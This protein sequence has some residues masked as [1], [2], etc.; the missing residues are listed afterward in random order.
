M[1]YLDCHLL[2]S[3]GLQQMIGDA[4]RHSRERADEL[5]RGL[6]PCVLIAVVV[7]LVIPMMPPS[8]SI[9]Y[10]WHEGA[11]VDIFC[12][13]RWV[14]VILIVFAFS[15]CGSLK[16]PF[17]IATAVLCGA[18]L[19]STYVN[20]GSYRDWAYDWFAY[21][22]V[23]LLV[24]ALCKTRPKEL[25]WGILVATASMAL[26]NVASI[27]ICPLGVYDPLVY[28]YGNRN[29]AYQLSF[30]MMTCTLLLDG[31][32]GASFSAR[33]FVVILL[34]VMQVA[35]AHSVTSCIA[36]AFAVIGLI[37]I[38]WSAPRKVLNGLTMVAAS[39]L[40]FVLVV[41]CRIQD[42]LAPL[43]SAL[44]KNV[45][46]SG[47]TPIWDL[48]LGLFNGEG[49]VFGY[50]VSGNALIQVNGVHYAH[51]HNIYLDAWF[52]GGLVALLAMGALVLM[53]AFRLYRL[54]NARCFAMLAIMLGAY[55]IV[56][57]TEPMTRVSFFIFLALCYHWPQSVAGSG[58]AM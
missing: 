8:P 42:Y 28:F 3:E 26:C 49:A 29:I 40:S 12:A 4:L 34:A 56:G 22:S 32:R 11:L 35:L 19:V 31:M 33:S 52:L 58:R 45:T 14:S 48:A 41:V 15:L 25:A 44:G 39:L 43:V 57:I 46:F 2:G 6:N 27:V 21:I 13:W 17:V 20:G 23:V 36:L 38:R 7:L 53:S 51:T 54:R 16:N 24:A 47:R 10:N 1:I 50:G 18:V 55:L 37:L 30:L 9:L 5:L